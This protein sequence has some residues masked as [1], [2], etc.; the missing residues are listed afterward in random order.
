MFESDVIPD[1]GKTDQGETES[2][3]P[4]ESDVIPDSGKTIEY[5]G[6]V[7]ILFESDVIPDSGKTSFPFPVISQS[8]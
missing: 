5:A 7:S 2:E 6:M 4:F 3:V 1:S 8:V